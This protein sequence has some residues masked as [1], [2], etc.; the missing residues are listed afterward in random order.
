MYNRAITRPVARQPMLL[1]QPIRRLP[2]ARSVART[3][4]R[5][6]EQLRP[7]PRPRYLPNAPD[8]G[9]E[10]PVEAF[11]P[12]T[13]STLAEG[14]LSRDAAEFVIELLRKLTPSRE[15]EGQELFYRWAQGKFG[16]HWRYADSTTVLTAASM[17][18]RPKSYLE[19]GV[20]RG[21]SAA[22]VGATAPDC[23]IYGFD[24]WLPD[25]AGLQN[26]GPDFVRGELRA[27]GHT[28]EV[29]LISGDSH[30]TM[31][32]FLRQHPGL[33]FDLVTVDG[34]HSL[35]GAARDLA[36][37]LPRLKIGGVI[38]FDDL[39]SAPWLMRVW[40]WFVK[41]DDRFRSWEFTEA[42]AGIGAAI[43]IG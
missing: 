28:G 10:A 31:P 38:V 35:G 1:L 16:R 8:T 13:I 43:R 5:G 30:R 17:L 42:G 41:E 23:A 34:D 24:L 27:A 21:R 22:V 29:T 15:A 7:L 2:A 26:P 6:W 33:Y 12:P 39:C 9:G 32:P 19:I 37:V 36:N 3:L 14:S 40:R 18:I 20:R 11:F 4:R 25:Y